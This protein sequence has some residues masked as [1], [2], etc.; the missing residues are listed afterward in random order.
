M[1]NQLSALEQAEMNDTVIKHLNVLYA[2]RR[3]FIKVEASERI[4]RALHHNV[5]VP[6]EQFLSEDCVF[7]KRER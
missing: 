4:K 7:Y 3:A 1:M 5:R 6:K 2:A